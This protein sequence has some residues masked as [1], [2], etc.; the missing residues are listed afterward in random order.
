[1]EKMVDLAL[2]LLASAVLK[3]V[4]MEKSAG[5]PSGKMLAVG[6]L[7]TALCVIL[8]ATSLADDPSLLGHMPTVRSMPT[9][10]LPCRYRSSIATRSRTDLPSSWSCWTS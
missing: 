10:V 8:N 3:V 9:G 2:R 5:N 1:M 6:M 7:A 4:R